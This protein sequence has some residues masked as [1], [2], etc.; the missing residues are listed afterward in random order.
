MIRRIRWML[1]DPCNKDIFDRLIEG[2]NADQFTTAV[3]SGFIVDI[4]RDE[5][6]Q[7]RFIE[8][9]E[10]SESLVD[11]FGNET[12]I[13]HIVYNQLEFRIQKKSPQLEIYNSPR[14]INA[15]INRLGEFTKGSAAIFSPEISVD[16]WLESLRNNTSSMT[17]IGALIAD[18]KLGDSVVAKAVLVGD[19]DVRTFVKQITNGKNY[20]LI[21]AIV[22]VRFGNCEAKFT[23]NLESRITIKSS[24]AGIESSLRNCLKSIL[25]K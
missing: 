19:Q 1:I 20:R 24:D 12:D 2:I 3:S 22:K 16:S 5:F 6:T 18:L 11:P 4:S 7:A 10:V 13:K 14:K 23:I 8:K 15:F 21:Q 25:K 9:S 17:T